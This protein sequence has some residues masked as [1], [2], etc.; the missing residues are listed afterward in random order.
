MKHLWMTLWLCGWAGVLSA[1][2]VDS[3][4]QT[5]SEL[6]I[7]EQIEWLYQV[8]DSLQIAQPAFAKSCALRGLTMAEEQEDLG[9]QIHGAFSLGQVYYFSGKNDS[10]LSLYKHC[11]ENRKDATP[12]IRTSQLHILMARAWGRAAAFDSASTAFSLARQAAIS[13]K[14]RAAEAA[15]LYRQGVMEDGR[16]NHALAVEFIMQAL[17]I[18]EAEGNLRGAAFCYNSLGTIQSYV[19]KNEEAIQNYQQAR[20][21]FDSIGDQINLIHCLNNMGSIYLYDQPDTARR[22]IEKALELS[23]GI[24]DGMTRAPIFTNLAALAYGE[25]NMPQAL[26]YDLEVL[27]IYQT[28]GNQAQVANAMNNIAYVYREMGDFRN[29]RTYA[30]QSL[31]LA[32]ELKARRIARQAMINLSTISRELGDYEN[33]YFYSQ[34]YIYLNDTLTH[35]SNRKQIS[36]LQVQYE[37]EKKEREIEQQA[38]QIRQRNL[39]IGLLILA[40]GMVGIVAFV[41]FQRQKLTRQAH[42]LAQ[43]KIA[44]LEQERRLTAMSAMIEGQETERTRIA[45]DLH[46]GLGGLLSSVK[47]RLS[48]LASNPNQP[49]FYSQTDQLIDE[50]A[51]EVRRIAHNMVPGVLIRF[52]LIPA[53]Q[54]LCETIQQS[55]KLEVEFQAL[56]LKEKLSLSPT[57]EAMIYRV[58]QEL[59][60]NILKHAQASEALVQLALHDDTLE[61]TVEDDG[62]GFDPNKA[63]GGLGMQ[64]IQSRISFLHGTLSI[65]SQEGQGTSVLMYVPVGEGST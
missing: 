4:L 54:T 38:N 59:L 65:N 6:S 36:E 3:L 24:E 27:K 49:A 22:Y 42:E 41:L 25:K 15:A 13:E 60:Q 62:K 29:A 30:E 23:E 21:L 39:F 56:R 11:L 14:D 18:F 48:N 45:R 57:Q 40:V 35:E 1:T 17:P 44:T 16:G 63:E 19:K 5:R 7:P 31:T 51:Q 20:V 2:T 8:S 10:A 37:T 53:I 26:E 33:A 55:G 64:S 28:Y 43:Q 47:L 9:R 58:V 46:D 32:Q 34:Q 52:G 12:P 50:A 61:I